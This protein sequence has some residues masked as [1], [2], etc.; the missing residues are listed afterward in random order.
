MFKQF[1]F[2]LFA[3]LFHAALKSACTFQLT[4]N[5]DGSLVMDNHVQQAFDLLVNLRMEKLRIQFKYEETKNLLSNDMQWISD[6]QCMLLEQDKSIGF[7]EIKLYCEYVVNKKELSSEFYDGSLEKAKSVLKEAI[8]KRIKSSYRD[9]LLLK[10]Y[11]PIITKK[12]FEI[13]ELKKEKADLERQLKESFVI[14][15]STLKNFSYVFCIV[16][17]IIFAIVLWQKK[18]TVFAKIF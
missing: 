18:C 15:K 5:S 4:V 10:N 8:K 12:D 2:L 16:G 1:I 17:F 3:L 9:E 13:A 11:T 14:K 6:L 7:S